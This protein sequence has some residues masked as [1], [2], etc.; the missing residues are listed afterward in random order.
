MKIAQW[1]RK[2]D[3][4]A[5]RGKHHKLPAIKKKMETEATDTLKKINQEVH[6]VAKKTSTQ[7]VD[8]FISG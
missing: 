6:D 4:L 2:T 5:A 3:E 7:P 8:V 1:Q